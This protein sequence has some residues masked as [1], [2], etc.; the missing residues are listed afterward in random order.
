MVMR[1]DQEIDLPARL[2]WSPLR[3]IGAVSANWLSI[4][5]HAS[6]VTDSQW[7]AARGEG[8]DVA[9]DVLEFRNVGAC[10]GACAKHQA[11]AQRA[12]EPKRG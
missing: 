4:D 5:H 12:D 10:A 1:V 7:S 3:N 8:A 9:A 2:A 6:G 11:I